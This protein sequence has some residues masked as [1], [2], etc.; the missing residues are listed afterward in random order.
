MPEYCETAVIGARQPVCPRCQALLPWG[1]WPTH[2]AWHEAQS[3]PDPPG[4]TAE[5][6]VVFGHGE[7]PVIAPVAWFA[8]CDRLGRQEAEYIVNALHE[9]GFVIVHRGEPQ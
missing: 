7:G 9:I 8:L 2:Q 4:V 5:P 1:D 6:A 3:R